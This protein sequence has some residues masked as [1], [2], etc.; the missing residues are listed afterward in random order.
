MPRLPP[1]PDLHSQ[2][3]VLIA[4]HQGNVS[5]AAE[6]LGVP[7]LML[8]RF[9]KSG[10][11]LARN[12]EALRAGF[13]GVRHGG[14]A[15]DRAALHRKA[16]TKYERNSF[17]SRSDIAQLRGMLHHLVRALDAYEAEGSDPARAGSGQTSS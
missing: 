8:W 16:K 11:A 4:D 10:S 1:D 12:L 3:R 5:A 15:S 7:Y 2:V 13:E 17:L 14:S 6:A 9:E